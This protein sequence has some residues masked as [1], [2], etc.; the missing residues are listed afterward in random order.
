MLRYAPH[1][2]RIHY[3]LTPAEQL[4]FETGFFDLLTVSSGVHWFDIE[5]FIA[6]ARRVLKSKGWLVPSL[7]RHGTRVIPGRAKTSHPRGLILSKS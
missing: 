6:E 7:L 2:D 4:P 3:T 1:N 5:R